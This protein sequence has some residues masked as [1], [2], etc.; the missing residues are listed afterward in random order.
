MHCV[1]GCDASRSCLSYH[2]H[3]AG[4]KMSYQHMQMRSAT[5]STQTSCAL[6]GAWA[7]FSPALRS[8]RRAAPGHRHRT[9]AARQGPHCE[10]PAP[11]RRCLTGPWASPTATVLAAAHSCHQAFVSTHFYI[12]RSRIQR[13][14]GLPS[15]GGRPQQEVQHLRVRNATAASCTV[16]ICFPW[17]GEQE[18]VFMC[19][20]R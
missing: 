6:L 10:P 12:F 11:H 2:A 18:R 7:A 15:P 4:L 3:A 13:R 14:S 17:W 19:S 8:P 9:P 1:H 16:Q 20:A 5:I